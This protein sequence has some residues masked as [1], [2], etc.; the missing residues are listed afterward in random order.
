MVNYTQDSKIIFKYIV[1][2]SE[3]G[4]FAQIELICRENDHYDA[5]EV[6]T[7]LLES[8]KIKDPRPLIHVFYRHGWMH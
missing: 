3:V 1:A 2:A 4:Q 5:D 6:K 8:N 7:F